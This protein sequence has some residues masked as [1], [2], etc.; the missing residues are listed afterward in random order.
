MTEKREGGGKISPLMNEDENGGFVVINSSPWAE[1]NLDNPALLVSVLLMKWSVW[2]V[3][4]W[5]VRRLVS[6]LF[7]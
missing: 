5:F 4:K 2:I 1:V 3:L 7:S 6:T